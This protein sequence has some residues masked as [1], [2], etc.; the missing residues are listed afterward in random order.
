M[1]APDWWNLIASRT[2]TPTTPPPQPVPRPAPQPSGRADGAP[3]WWGLVRER[4]PKPPVGGAAQPG[5]PPGGDVEGYIRQAA[6]QRGIDPDVAVRVAQSEGGLVP[7]RT[8]SFP[9]GKSFWPFQLHYG[10]AGTPY[11]QY[12][13]VA[14]MG[15]TFTEKT[16]WQPG[17][18]EAWRAATDYAL[19][20]AKRQGWGAWYGARKLGITGFRGITRGGPGLGPQGGGGSAAAPPAPALGAA[21]S[22]APATAAAAPA[23]A[24]PSPAPAWWSLVADA[25]G[26]ARRR[27]PAG[28]ALGTP[29]APQAAGGAPRALGEAPVKQAVAASWALSNLGSREFYNLCQRFIEQAYGTGGQFGSAAAAGKALFKTAD[30]AEADVG[31]LVFFRPDASNGYAGHAAIYLGNGEMVGATDA[32]VTR[33]NIFTNPYWKNLLV[34][35]GDPPDAWKG[36]AS[37]ADLLEGAGQLVGSARAAAGGTPTA[38]SSGG[39]RPGPAPA[40]WSLVAGV[41]PRV[42]LD[43]GGR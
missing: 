26:A 36:R 21:R 20:A 32:G 2:S 8:G 12:G 9:T 22:G 27:P 25:A 42:P 13:T 16:G 5:A 40:W 11:A 34:G 1:P 17:D 41:G 38:A 19:D 43:V 4:T 37:S 3:A 18:P 10:G 30:P 7:N 28:P 14:G 35:F 39:A 33:D 24:P 15:N 31:D 29:T 23:A 6:A